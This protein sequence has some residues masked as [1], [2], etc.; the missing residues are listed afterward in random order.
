MNRHWLGGIAAIALLVLIG[1]AGRLMPH[2]PNFGP[3]AAIAMFAGFY[4]R[5][6]SCAV[7]VPLLAMLIADLFIGFY[8]LPTMVAV[9]ASLAIPVCCRPLLAGRYIALRIGACAAICSLMF[10]A[11]TNLAVWR[12]GGLYE[13]SPGGLVTCYAA[14]LPF[15]KYTLA[16]DVVWCTALFGSYGLAK[17]VTS[18]RTAEAAR[19]DR[20]TGAW[21]G[22][23]PGLTIFVPQSCKPIS[24]VS[25]MGG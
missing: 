19:R 22:Q 14:A 15:L 4:F 25:G 12:F 2:P 6:R 13:P 11:V 16:G 5:C 9:Y 7:A 18:P 10:F 1:V 23:E 8:E 21:P 17:W 24:C 20:D 3:I